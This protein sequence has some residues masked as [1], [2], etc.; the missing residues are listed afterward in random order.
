MQ[1][2]SNAVANAQELGLLQFSIKPQ[3]CIIEVW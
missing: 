1:D 3:I 2:Y